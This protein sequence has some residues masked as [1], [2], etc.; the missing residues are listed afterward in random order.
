MKDIPDF[1][2]IELAKPVTLSGANGS[3]ATEYNTI[4]LQE[5]NVDQLSKFIKAT[6]K[7]NAIDAMKM[8][9]SLI[10]GLPLAVLAKVGSRDFFKAQSYLMNFLMPTAEDDPEGNV[11]DSQ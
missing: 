9:I 1:L 5:P 11:G 7:E 3:D 8:L 2:D 6:Q 4:H 10:S